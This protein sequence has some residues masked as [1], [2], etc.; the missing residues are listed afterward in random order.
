MLPSEA[1]TQQ[2]EDLVVNSIRNLMAGIPIDPEVFANEPTSADAEALRLLDSN[3][4]RF[5][6]NYI[7]KQKNPD[8]RIVK[9]MTGGDGFSQEKFRSAAES[10]EEP[11]PE[12]SEQRRE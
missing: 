4:G 7:A 10:V 3:T 5:A 8:P 9:A 1:N 12:E 11:T 2:H 6:K